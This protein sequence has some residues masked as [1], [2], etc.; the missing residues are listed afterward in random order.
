[1]CAGTGGDISRILDSVGLILVSHTV[2]FGAG[3]VQSLA[4]CMFSISKRWTYVF[5][6]QQGSLRLNGARSWWFA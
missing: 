6:P 2:S 4:Y 5:E 1:V 3:R